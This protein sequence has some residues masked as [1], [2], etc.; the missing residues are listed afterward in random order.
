MEIKTKITGAGRRR[1]SNRHAGYYRIR[2]RV[3][4]SFGQPVH[5]GFYLNAILDGDGGVD[6]NRIVGLFNTGCHG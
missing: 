6:R 3:G 5:I 4:T 2:N 1:S